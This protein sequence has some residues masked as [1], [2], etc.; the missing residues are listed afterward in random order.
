MTRPDEI[1]R[2][3]ESMKESVSGTRKDNR[4]TGLLD[5]EPYKSNQAWPGRRYALVGNSYCVE[6]RLIQGN[7]E[8]KRT[9]CIAVVLERGRQ[10]RKCVSVE[11]ALEYPGFRECLS[12]F[13]LDWL[14]RQPASTLI[15][16]AYDPAGHLVPH[17]FAVWRRHRDDQA[18]TRERDHRSEVSLAKP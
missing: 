10:N 16:P 5:L 11:D 1:V 18:V 13:E 8:L 9:A 4:R 2:L 14:G 17:A 15:G 12:R 7:Q 6:T 3:L